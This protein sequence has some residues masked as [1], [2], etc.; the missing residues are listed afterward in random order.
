MENN[1]NIYTYDFVGCAY[2]LLLLVSNS[3]V[4]VVC[5]PT[6]TSTTT[7]MNLLP[8]FTFA[9]CINLTLLLNYCSIHSKASPPSGIEPRT[10]NCSSVLTSF[11]SE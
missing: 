11:G 5:R 3:K 9:F 1:F 10:L 4:S 8:L 2:M 6:T 7:Y